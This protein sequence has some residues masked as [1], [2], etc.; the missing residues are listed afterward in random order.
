[1]E[2][3]K[4]IWRMIKEISDIQ[5]RSSVEIEKFDNLKIEIKKDLEEAEEFFN[6]LNKNNLI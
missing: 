4:E 6:K 2:N 3:E 1:M 5:T